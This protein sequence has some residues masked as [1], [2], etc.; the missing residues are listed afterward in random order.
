[1]LDFS[2]F[3]QQFIILVFSKEHSQYLPQGASLLALVLQILSKS[4]LVL[5]ILLFELVLLLLLQLQWVS[6]FLYLVHHPF[7]LIPLEPYFHLLDFYLY[8]S[9]HLNLSLLLQYQF[10]YNLSHLIIAV[11][12]NCFMSC[13]CP[14]LN[15]D[16]Y[17]VLIGLQSFP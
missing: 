14:F 10:C 2:A 11:R 7:K 1:M 4:S 15:H 17:C 3:L 6:Q 5:C 13:L 9:I 12:F 16:R 8:Q